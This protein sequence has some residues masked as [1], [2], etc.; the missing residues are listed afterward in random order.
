MPKT[1]SPTP[2][3]RLDDYSAAAFNRFGEGHLPAHLGIEIVST[4]AQKL[5]CR[6]PIGTELMA[7]NGYLHAGT[8]VAV[9]D[10]LCGY[11]CVVNLPEGA[12]GFTTIELKSNFV[13]TAREGTIRC[14]ATPLHLGR[15]T[16]VWD[17]HLHEE[18][19]GRALAL[20]RCTQ[21]VLWK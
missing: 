11:G 18:G 10:S 16:Q 21:L 4:E 1:P 5:V 2:Y 12:L 7:P 13:G 17:A 15:T 9:A 14:E 8:L 20:F 6:A 19:S 3:P